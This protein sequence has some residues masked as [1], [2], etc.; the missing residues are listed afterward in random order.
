MNFA[1][2]ITQGLGAAKKQGFP[3]LNFRLSDIPKSLENGVFAVHLQPGGGSRAKSAASPDV[4]RPATTSVT[5]PG[6][7]YY[8]PRFHHGNELVCEVHCLEKP[9]INLP[10]ALEIRI[11]KKLREP[12]K[13]EHDEALV[14]QIESDAAEAKK[15][16]LS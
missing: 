5:L 1:A 2:T 13:F 9:E 10:P 8:G 3:T 15:I 11:E 16:L 4:S 6:V 14:K 12:Q 7:M